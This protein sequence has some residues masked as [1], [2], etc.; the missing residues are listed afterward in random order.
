LK[1]NAIIMSRTLRSAHELEGR[2]A[3]LTIEEATI[4][5]L[6]AEQAKLEFDYHDA[7]E[8]PDEVDQPLSEIAAT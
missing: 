7:D 3:D 5:A 4:H 8:L 2:L 6:N 1:S